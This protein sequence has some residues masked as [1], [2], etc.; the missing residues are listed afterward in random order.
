MNR[1]TN[2]DIGDFIGREKVKEGAEKW[3]NTKFNFIT[4]QREF[5]R[6]DGE[7]SISEFKSIDEIKDACKYSKGHINK[8]KRLFLGI[9]DKITFYFIFSDFDSYI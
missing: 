8:M 5:L 6:Q 1:K 3:E 4:L 9:I 2:K 7:K